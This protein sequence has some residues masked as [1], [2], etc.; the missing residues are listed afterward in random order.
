MAD[1]ES[2][3]AGDIDPAGLPAIAPEWLDDAAWRAGIKRFTVR[4]E[5]GRSYVVA[6]DACEGAHRAAAD[7]TNEAM[8]RAIW[9][10]IAADRGLV[11]R[12]LADMG[13]Q[14]VHQWDMER[15]DSERRWLDCR[16]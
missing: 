11:L 6:F 4:I 8:S 5:K 13:H 14:A 2:I 15:D 9:Q 1:V 16:R 12:L 7:T 10:A 3:A